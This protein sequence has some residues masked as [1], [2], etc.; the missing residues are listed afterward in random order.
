MANDRNN[1]NNNQ[2]PND[3]FPPDFLDNMRGFNEEMNV[4][5]QA[6]NIFN[7]NM[8]NMSNSFQSMAEEFA[9]VNRENNRERTRRSRDT[10]RQR[11]VNVEFDKSNINRFINREAPIY[12]RDYRPTQPKPDI[13]DV[14][15]QDYIPSH[16]QRTP[17]KYSQAPQYGGEVGSLLRED[18]VKNFR[19]LGHTI[20]PL[21][22]AQ[23]S[24]M[25][26]VMQPMQLKMSETM[27]RPVTD[28]LM[29]FEDLK[30]FGKGFAG[31]GA[32][33]EGF[34]QELKKS[35]LQMYEGLYQSKIMLSSSLGGDVAANQTINN[36]LKLARE[37]PIRTEEI[38]SSLT[39]LAVYP[40]V[41]PYLKSENFQRKLMETVS[42]LGMIV[43]EQGVGGAMFSLVEALSG[44]WRSMQMRFNVSP[45]VVQQLSGMTKAEMSS[46][47]EKLVEGLHRF[48][49]KS[50]GLDV[51]EKQKYTFTK[52]VE[53]FG[54][55]L[56]MLTK[57]VFES[58]GLYKTITAGAT[59]FQTGFSSLAG[60]NEFM[61]Y[62]GN[63]FKP[64]QQQTNQAFAKFAGVPVGMYET[65]SISQI[66]QVV[67]RNF[68]NLSMDEIGQRFRGLINDMG[69]VWEGMANNINKVVNSAFGATLSDIG[70]NISTVVGEEF[71]GL[72]TN[73]IK[74]FGANMVANPMDMLKVVG[75]MAVPTLALLGGA[76]V[77]A[78][79]GT[80]QI[81]KMPLKQRML[82]F[83]EG[84]YGTASFRAKQEMFGGMVNMPEER[85]LFIPKMTAA[86]RALAKGDV[87]TF[88]NKSFDIAKKVY[89]TERVKPVETVMGNIK[90]MGMKPLR[91]MEILKRTNI[92][93]RDLE[94]I[95]N[96]IMESGV[97]GKF[98]ESALSDLDVA[99]RSKNIGEFRNKIGE[100]RLL[101]M[102]QEY[103]LP[104]NLEGMRLSG[105]TKIL[106]KQTGF[107]GEAY[108]QS[109]GL[110]QLY[111]A[112]FSEKALE[113]FM[114]SYVANRVRQ[115]V[116][117]AYIQNPRA[118][119]NIQDIEKRVRRGFTTQKRFVNVSPETRGILEKIP[120]EYG[121]EV[122]V[123]GRRVKMARITPEATKGNIALFRK[124]AE[125]YAQ[126]TPSAKNKAIRAALAEFGAA[127]ETEG[128]VTNVK[129][130]ELWAGEVIDN[131]KEIDRTFDD[132]LSEVP[133]E[134]GKRTEQLRNI[135][136]QS[137]L[138]EGV[139]KPFRAGMKYSDLMGLV[140][141]G[142]GAE[143]YQQLLKNKNIDVG[144]LLDNREVSM[145]IDDLE[146]Q[147]KQI[148]EFQVKGDL[149]GLQQFVKGTETGLNEINKLFKTDVVGE[150]AS[151]APNVKE[152]VL[153]KSIGVGIKA[154]E[155][156]FGQ[157]AEQ[158]RT[159]G[160]S[161]KFMISGS[162][163]AD[164]I[165][166]GL[167]GANIAENLKKDKTMGAVLGAAT[168]LAMTAGFVAKGGQGSLMSGKYMGSMMA[169]MS[170]MQLAESAT[171]GYGKMEAYS[172]N[173]GGYLKK[174]KQSL[175]PKDY[176]M[177]ESLIRPDE[178]LNLSSQ[179]RHKAGMENVKK[180]ILG[181]TG[182][183]A[184][185][186]GAMAGIGVL[187]SAPVSIPLLLGMGALGMGTGVASSYLSGR[188]NATPEEQ[189]KFTAV[190]GFMQ[191]Q[192]LASNSLKKVNNNITN[193]EQ[194]GKYTSLTAAETMQ[195]QTLYAKRG[196]LEDLKTVN[197]EGIKGTSNIISQ[198][199]MEGGKGWMV[200]GS[201]YYGNNMTFGTEQS[202]KLQRFMDMATKSAP[203]ESMNTRLGKA[204][205]ANVYMSDVV[206]PK[207]QENIGSSDVEKRQKGFQD[208]ANVTSKTL[209]NL[210]KIGNDIKPENKSQ[211][212]IQG[213]LVNS[214]L[215]KITIPE[216]AKEKQGFI[217]QTAPQMSNLFFKSY[218]GETF[219]TD[220]R[221]RDIFSG[222]RE[223]TG[224]IFKSAGIEQAPAKALELTRKEFIN[225]NVEKSGLGENQLG[226]LY[227]TLQKGFNTAFSSAQVATRL[228]EQKTTLGIEEKIVK[229]MLTQPA[230]KGFIT[231]A[232]KV[233]STGTTMS[234]M[235]GYTPLV[236]PQDSGFLKN[237]Q[238]DIGIAEYAQGK[239]SQYQQKVAQGGM[240]TPTE[241][242]DLNKNQGIL[243]N[244]MAG[245]NTVFN[246]TKELINTKVN[247]S[248]EKFGKTVSLVTQM[249]TGDYKSS[250]RNIFSEMANTIASGKMTAE[251][252]RQSAAEDIKKIQPY[253]D[254]LGLTNA[255]I[256]TFTE[257]GAGGLTQYQQALMSK[258]PQELEKLGFTP[259]IQKTITGI[260]TKAKSAQDIEL[261]AKVQELNFARQQGRSAVQATFLGQPEVGGLNMFTRNRQNLRD[262]VR[263][264]SAQM[265]VEL[266]DAYESTNTKQDKT[267]ILQA[268]MGVGKQAAAFG[269]DN[270]YINTISGGKFSKV[271]DMIVKDQLSNMQEQKDKLF[272]TLNLSGFG[273]EKNMLNPTITQTQAG[274]V[275][276]PP[277][278]QPTQTQAGAVQPPP[279][280]TPVKTASEVEE[281]VKNGV[282]KAEQTGVKQLPTTVQGMT[283]GQGCINICGTG[284]G[285]GI[286]GTALG[287]MNGVVASATRT[288]Q[289]ASGTQQ[290]QTF[291]NE[292]N[293][294]INKVEPKEQSNIPTQLNA[295][296]N[297]G[298]AV[299]GVGV[300]MKNPWIMGAGAG[301]Q[302]LTGI[303]KL[304]YGSGGNEQPETEQ[305]ATMT[306]MVSGNEQQ[307]IPTEQLLKV[308]TDIIKNNAADLGK[309]LPNLNSQEPLKNMNYAQLLPT[310]QSEANLNNIP[311][312]IEA[313]SLKEGFNVESAINTGM[314]NALNGVSDAVNQL[315]TESN[316][317]ALGVLSNKNDDPN[318]LNTATV[319]G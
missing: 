18:I 103:M 260:Q 267:K 223:K 33:L 228:G 243:K 229:N 168:P 70:N 254:K 314:D 282:I 289:L 288:E 46:S 299:F 151:V 5:Q 302:A 58:T 129:S 196:V 64:Y 27:T 290:A 221:S 71:A 143:Q 37:Y 245:L 128:G 319:Y 208:L 56:Q 207:I 250:M 169:L 159:L 81:E 101:E 284:A 278:Q 263:Q 72:A 209:E 292:G 61:G 22:F 306:G 62:V 112:G 262:K 182:G 13:L 20:S 295:A 4:A 272:A 15:S 185:A 85:Q 135:L 181:I 156:A 89:T 7:Q 248:L 86:E 57:D 214:T 126:K 119:L 285:G 231:S 147:S 125:E 222:I 6:M 23:Y 24:A 274:A 239:I 213:R 134:T 251:Y 30:S 191:Q 115:E 241:M 9:N 97:K 69:D 149:S 50:I 21:S 95:V 87:N 65:N 31:V 133:P 180:N 283:G 197:I 118:N 29:P 96:R 14:F 203:N 187:A 141:T 117:S 301:I 49:S 11:Q 78:A 212:E 311:T 198:K 179:S 91:N 76:Q 88:I 73:V 12:T 177:V 26:G 269:L 227:D 266:S 77:A 17:I 193:L 202:A 183:T 152:K 138:G 261:N 294:G 304:I 114:Q 318:Y 279:T 188:G 92:K 270:T 220:N 264:A 172:A 100:R 171:A 74:A 258:T 316:S 310:I 130:F 111:Q 120:S 121:R 122:E 94:G 210:N 1:R 303:G 271:Q 300:A 232:Y 173:V 90:E 205:A 305:P 273:S 313:G 218:M 167:S 79:A 226:Q 136:K 256:G 39:R 246:T 82:N 293:T 247:S 162:M 113:D 157:L 194:V 110:R 155:S 240:L 68:K 237:V 312:T 139:L 175:S 25:F 265:M 287:G 16:A 140:T 45:E 67:E 230:S 153:L 178:Y 98:G 19:Q 199:V 280:Q 150:M 236:R 192:D 145:F 224:E 10:Q 44:S 105:L 276:P 106:K 249:S 116:E 146:G 52:Q 75:T 160:K 211:V 40:Q 259:E 42:G 297:V 164:A 174:Y 275:Q 93:P 238:R 144:G 63:M 66:A 253:L 195:L 242:E 124:I 217:N 161:S 307:E 55:A 131:M 47:P 317:L 286:G 298:S 184:L 60:S 107:V 309:L 163:I 127:L 137:T 38:L 186:M 148:S 108:T 204:M 215:N 190:K 154:N 244:T 3:I 176:K 257:R 291:M 36:A 233:S 158:Q 28:T 255:T 165:F 142:E 268:M 83:R 8:A 201:Q 59:M 170:V 235:M 189:Y 35:P 206:M 2:N 34:M 54:D 109:P 123:D 219:A 51:M 132:I 104:R 166:G 315:S 296:G 84:L 200:T 32:S 102:E 41:K 216:N 234:A 80:R 99:L 43:P 53:N 225:K 281:G 277:T 252:K 48:V 308:N